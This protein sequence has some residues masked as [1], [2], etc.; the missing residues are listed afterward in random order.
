MAEVVQERTKY[1]VKYALRCE[2]ECAEGDSGFPE[3]EEGP[4]GVCQTGKC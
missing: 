3:S 1:V 4:V 2:N